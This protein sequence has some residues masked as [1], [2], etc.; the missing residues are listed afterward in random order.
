ML[1]D[2]V[3][4]LSMSP[5]IFL[6]PDRLTHLTCQ[7]KTWLSGKNDSKVDFRLEPLLKLKWHEIIGLVTNQVVLL[8]R[9]FNSKHEI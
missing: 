1:Y 9:I 8:E 3:L 4:I 7:H 6:Y 5:P 2:M